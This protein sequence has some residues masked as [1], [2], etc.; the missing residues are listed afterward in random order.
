M[1]APAFFIIFCAISACQIND[2]GKKSHHKEK[3]NAMFTIDTLIDFNQFSFNAPK[4]WQFA[5]DDSLPPAAD[6]TSRFRFHNENGKEIHFEYGLSAYGEQFYPYP[7]PAYRRAGYLN[8]E[9]DTSG[10]IFSD[11]PRLP[12]LKKKSI[13]EFS[14]L[15]V[16]GFPSFC[17][18][19][20]NYAPGYSGLYIDS[21]GTEAGHMVEFAV[22]GEDLDSLEV[23]QL[24]KIF[25]TLKIR[26]YKN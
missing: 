3:I 2:A 23:A 19:P 4:G 20:K 26:G 10:W 24:N 9:F 21:I 17:Y 15:D 16:S 22:Y 8:R 6:A 1:K 13:Y 11:D 12:E 5:V 14:S 7:I 25:K 18:N